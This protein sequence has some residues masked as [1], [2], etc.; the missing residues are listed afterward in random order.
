M[1]MVLGSAS[2]TNNPI[3]DCSEVVTLSSPGIS[4]DQ[5]VLGILK[6]HSP[7]DM[8]QLGSGLRE[9]KT[10]FTSTKKISASYC[11]SFSSDFVLTIII[12]HLVT[13]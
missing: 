12:V 7:F 9:I 4:R 8:C 6:M 13:L 1:G 5:H 11:E 2:T 10:T 3:R